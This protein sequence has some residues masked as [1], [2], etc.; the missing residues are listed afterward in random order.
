MEAVGQSVESGVDETGG[1]GYIGRATDV[2]NPG[3]S[4]YLGKEIEIRFT[5]PRVAV[6]LQCQD[7]P[8]ADQHKASGA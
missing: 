1:A 3:P 5:V 7:K 8:K 2:S 6:P 4:S